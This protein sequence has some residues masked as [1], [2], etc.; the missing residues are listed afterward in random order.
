MPPRR[1]PTKKIRVG[2]VEVGGDATV[3]IQ[4]MCTT[5]TPDARATVTQILELATSGADIVRVTVPDDESADGI[6]LALWV[7]SSSLN[8]PPII[9]DIHFRHDL[10][11]K[12][13]EYGVD[14]LRLNPGNIKDAKKIRQVAREA[15]DRG[16]PIRVGANAGSLHTQFLDKHGGPTPEALVESAMWE[17]ALLED[18][19]FTDIK[20]SV[21]HSD[22]WQMIES[23][24]LLSETTDYPLHLG[25]TEAGTAYKGGLK[26]AVGIGT[27]LAEGIG[28]TIRV[29]LAADPVEEVKAGKAILQ[30]LGLRREGVDV[31][32][33]PTCGR[34]EGD[35]ITIATKVE[36]ALA[37]M[38]SP[39]QV[40]VMGCLVNG[41]G[42]AKGADI[43]LA[44]TKH[45]GTIF[46]HGQ[47]VREVNEHEMLDVLLDEARRM[48]EELPAPNG[49]RK[50][51]PVV[52]A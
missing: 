23:Y 1:R 11:L 20:I 36:E 12:V 3:S 15:K 27:L 6:A 25:V 38:K 51:L 47:R 9:A 45:G 44:L 4:S 29:S 31:V 39:I 42:E 17:V 2:S 26:S 49:D 14:G 30:S 40:A 43:G 41:P 18:E 7:L 48:A 24:R 50:H 34:V 5:R 28:D 33:C 10:A 35:V 52:S 21:K 37:E 19:G 32:A 16:I 8:P 13:I 46:K 22:A